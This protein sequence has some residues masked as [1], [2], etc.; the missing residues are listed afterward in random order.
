M[1]FRDAL[2]TVMHDIF[3]KIALPDIAFKLPSKRLKKIETG[4]TEV[5]TYFMEMIHQRKLAGGDVRLS[6]TGKNDLLG[7]LVYATADSSVEG[8]ED[9]ESEKEDLKKRS[10]TLSDEEGK[11]GLSYFLSLEIRN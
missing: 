10:G 11:A 7:A 9:E 2:H 8:L 3:W 1:S 4:F 6:E 5:R